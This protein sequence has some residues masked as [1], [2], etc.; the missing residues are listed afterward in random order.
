MK[1]QLEAEIYC[2][3][4]PLMVVNNFYN[5]QELDLIWK[6]L[7]FYTAPNKLVVAENYGGVVGYTNAKALILDDLYRN[8]ESDEKGVDYRNISNILTVNRKLFE[9]GV[10]D[11]FAS[12]HGCVSI[13]N[14]TNHD[15]TKVRYYHDGQYYDPHTDKSTMFLAFSYFYK[16]P[17]KFVGGDLEFPKYDFKLPCTNNSIVIFPGWVEHGVRKVKIKNSDYYDGWGR[18][19]ITSFFSCRDKKK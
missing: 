17:K 4:F 2:E 18:Y 1:E 13:A 9:C 15:I 19:A 14:K 8:Y 7:D 5:Q 3:P 16:E 12:I 10:L 6:E 11:T